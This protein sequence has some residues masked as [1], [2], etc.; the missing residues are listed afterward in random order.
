[1]AGNST[2]GKVASTAG[3][4]LGSPNASALQRSLASSALAQAGTSKSIETK[5][6]ATL[7]NPN[8]SAATKTLAG[9]VTS[10]ARK[11]P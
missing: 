8:A 2:G 3:R 11:T 9:S 7:K 6:S 1:M 10:Q 5:A 4:T